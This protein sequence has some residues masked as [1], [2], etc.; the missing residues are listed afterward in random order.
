[1]KEKKEE[2][3]ALFGGSWT[4]KSFLHSF[5]FVI[6]AGTNGY[7]QNNSHQQSYSIQ[8][9]SNQTPRYERVLPERTWP[10]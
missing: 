4:R 6:C 2:N 9:A 1:M 10:H 7:Y 5:G 8:S 3:N